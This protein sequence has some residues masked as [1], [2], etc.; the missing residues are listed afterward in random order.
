MIIQKV[1]KGITHYPNYGS[2]DRHINYIWTDGIICRWWQKIGSLPAHKIPQRLTERNLFWHQNKYDTPD[3]NLGGIPFCEETPFISTTAGTVIRDSMNQINILE[4]AKYTA[5][6]FAT[7]GWQET[8]LVVFCYVFVLSKKA[9]AHQQFAEEI[10]ELNIY[11]GYSPYQPEGEIT[12]KIQIPTTQIEKIEVWEKSDYERAFKNGT[13]DINQPTSTHIN[14]A[15]LSPADYTNIR[16][17][18]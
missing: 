7:Q 18:L 1:L 8:G 14:P 9:V 6:K 4:P 15:Y 16:E 10:R 2:L 13:F 11:T 17:V 12:A 5:L 3:P